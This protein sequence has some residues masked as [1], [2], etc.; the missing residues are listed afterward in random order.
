MST[1]SFVKASILFMYLRIFPDEKFR[2]ILWCTQLFNCLLLIAFVAGTVGACQP[3]NFFWS[4][5]TGEM[6][7][8]C[9]N[10]NAF[11]L[12][13]GVFNV[14][15]DLWM[16]ILPATQLYSLRMKL[17]K[18]IGVML[19][20]GV[21]ILISL[22]IVSAY[23]IKTLMVFATSYNVTGWFFFPSFPSLFKSYYS[24]MKLANPCDPC[25]SGFFFKFSLVSHRSLCR[26][27][28][29]LSAEHTSSLEDIF[30]K[31][32]RYYPRV[33]VRTISDPLQKR[34]PGINR[35]GSL[36]KTVCSVIQRS[37]DSPLDWRFQQI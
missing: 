34:K 12:C 32:S 5:W 19:M 15:L 3:L 1:L 18:K 13:H 2:I 22:T 16:L 9:F 33:K 31:A 20:F 27:I 29:C 30:S 14:V 35:F 6:K 24:I 11:V 7:G 17:G 23:R 36:W 37:F 21:G 10:L 28:R 8:K 25:D 26:N 4:G